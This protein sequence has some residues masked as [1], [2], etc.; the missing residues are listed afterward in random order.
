MIHPNYQTWAGENPSRS[1]ER[2]PVPFEPHPVLRLTESG[3]SHVWWANLDN[4][5]LPVER[6][7]DT[8]SLDERARTERFVFAR[9]RERFIAVRYLLR[10]LLGS[11]LHTDPRDLR[12]CYGRYGKP[13]LAHPEFAAGS[14]FFNITHSGNLVAFAINRQR[15]VGIDVERVAPAVAIS[16]IA[17]QFFSAH[18]IAALGKCSSDAQRRAFFTLWT[19]KEAFAK[20]TGHGLGLDLTGL[21]FSSALEAERLFVWAEGNG[22]ESRVW[23]VEKLLLDN[24]HKAALATEWRY[25]TKQ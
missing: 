10:H 9:D 4:A 7:Y 22:E 25:R 14:L 24:H 21:D 1:N 19:F 13:A 23:C 11:Y 3:G 2:T 6:L 15:A 18:E 8:L 20:A 5:A 17:S 16:Q 12:F